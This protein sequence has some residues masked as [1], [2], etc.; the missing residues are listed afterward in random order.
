MN[1]HTGFVGGCGPVRFG[2][3]S[4]GVVDS[5]SC[6]SMSFCSGL[7]RS[8]VTNVLVNSENN[9]LVFCGSA[10]RR[11]SLLSMSASDTGKGGGTADG[12][13]EFD[14]NA[15]FTEPGM[16][17]E[18]VV[19]MET[20]QTGN[21]MTSTELPKGRIS[22]LPLFPLGLV[23]YPGA[24][25][26]LHIFEMR[27]RRMFNV[28]RESDSMFGVVMYDSEKKRMANI[29]CSALCTKFQPL[30]DGRILVV[31]EGK[32]RF[33]IIRIVKDSPYITALVE[34]FHDDTPDEDPV[35]TGVAVWDSLQEVLRLSN[36][37][38]S[39]G[40]KLSDNLTSLVPTLERTGG[41]GSE[42]RFRNAE[43]FSFGV[44][45]ILDMPVLQQQLLLQTKSLNL[46]LAKQKQLLDLA[47]Q[48]LAAQISIKAALDKKE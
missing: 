22:E 1:G 5:M 37:L 14:E 9:D 46:R 39:R 19:F 11:V 40:L 16:R 28:I 3:G 35:P 41:Q 44:S 24:Q 32:E 21:E 15:P 2:N 38:Y 42:E 6:R 27:Y 47:K 43:K 18:D 20:S 25:L 34:Y 17:V 48:Q 33:R 26:P 10:K 45:S 31:N 4:V 7:K 30:E 23:L 29:G 13:D 8:R 12:E 36:K